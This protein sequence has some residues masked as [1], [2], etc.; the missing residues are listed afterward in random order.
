MNIEN[1][2]KILQSLFSNPTR[3]HNIALS[4]MMPPFIDLATLV[5]LLSDSSCVVCAGNR[6]SAEY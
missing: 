3:K 5:Y 2:G 1:S 4:M 6:Q